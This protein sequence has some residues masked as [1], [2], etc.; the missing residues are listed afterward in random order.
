MTAASLAR[1]YAALGRGD[2]EGARVAGCELLAGDPCFA[3]AHHAIGLTYCAEGDLDDALPHLERAADLEPSTVRWTRDVGVVY[4]AVHRWSDCVDRLTPIVGSLD[5]QAVMA[6]LLAGVE[7]YRAESVLALVEGRVDWQVPTDLEARVAYGSALVAAK[8]LS[9]AE[10]LLQEC[11]ACAPDTLLVHDALGDL[12]EQTGRPEEELRHRAERVRLEP[13]SAR[14]RLGLAIALAERGQYDAA[15]VERLEADRLGLSESYEQSSRLFMMLSDPHETSASLLATARR[16]FASGGTSG[17]V[18][19]PGARRAP[20]R[21]RVGYV[22]GESRATPSYY[23]FRPFL[24]HHD[25]SV[26]DVTLFNTSPISDRFTQEFRQW[27]EHWRDIAGMP[28]KTV[29]EQILAEELDVAVD[30]SGHFP[31][32]GQQVVAERLAP[33]QMAYP[34][35]PGTTGNPSIDYVLTD[36]WTSPPG[37]ESEYRSGSTMCLPAIWGSTSHSRMST[38]GRFPVLPVASRPSGYA[39][40]STSSRPACGTHWRGSWLPCP[41]RRYS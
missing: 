32:N 10:P 1:I 16:T 28:A 19:H 12:F 39:S 9:E 17:R 21:L 22:S 5:T 18:A 35:Y 37:T 13:S 33:V 23:F 15:R 41:A 27:P 4:A 8:R 20:R 29:V 30:L 25:R 24:E 34:N 40:D 11:L 2:H 6:Y 7:T 31:Y 26:V 14:A 3:S 38:S 36:T